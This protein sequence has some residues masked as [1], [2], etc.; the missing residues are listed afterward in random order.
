MTAITIRISDLILEELRDLSKS[1]WVSQRQIIEKWITHLS[2][3]KR[4]SDL[5]KQ[6]KNY[7]NMI[8]SDNNAYKE[9]IYLADSLSK[10]Y[11]NLLANEDE[12][13]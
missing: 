8:K 6:M 3:E 12:N 2:K 11:L 5:I 7:S 10:D 4:K 9:E 13:K 1:F